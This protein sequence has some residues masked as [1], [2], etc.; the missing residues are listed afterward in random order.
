MKKLIAAA[1]L[2]AV[3]L[4]PARAFAQPTPQH[5]HAVDSPKVLIVVTQPLIVGTSILKPG[6]YKFQCR[7]FGGKTFLVV[8]VADTGKEIVRVPCVR[9]MLD[10]AVTETQFN[11]IVRDNGARELTSV[12]IKGEAV[13]HRVIAD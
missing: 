2:L 5:D 10:G 7:D 1:S 4:L 12:R 11:S 8:T 6:D 13:A 9:E 3:F